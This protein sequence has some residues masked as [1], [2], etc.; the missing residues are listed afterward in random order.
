MFGDLP[1]M[2]DGDSADVWVRQGQFRF[3]VSIGAPPDAFN[4][5]GQRWGMPLYRWDA[6]A[7]EGHAWWIARMRTLLWSAAK[8]CGHDAQ[9]QAPFSLWPQM[10]AKK[11]QR[12]QKAD[13]KG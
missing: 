13:K 5:E 4:P 12:G 7:A 1:F 9:A 6:M 3:D 8:A 10:P 2:V 11:A